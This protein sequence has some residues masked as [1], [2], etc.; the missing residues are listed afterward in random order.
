MSDKLSYR[1]ASLLKNRTGSFIE[2]YLYGHFQICNPY[3]DQVTVELLPLIS[4]SQIYQ[5]FPEK[6]PK[7]H[8]EQSLL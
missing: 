1:V 3:L 8:K 4:S 7:K 6:E 2:K 5:G